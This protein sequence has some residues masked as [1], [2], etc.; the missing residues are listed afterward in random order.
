MACPRDVVI[1]LADAVSLILLSGI[2]FFKLCE[3]RT[4][5]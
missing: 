3:T 2:L 1:I 4:T 5:R